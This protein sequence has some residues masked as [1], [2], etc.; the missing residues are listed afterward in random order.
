MPRTLIAIILFAAVCYST[1]ARADSDTDSRAGDEGTAM[2]R[3][4]AFGTADVVHSS[5]DRAD[6]SAAVDVVW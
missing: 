2:F 5:E 3:C 1:S 6:F 4:S